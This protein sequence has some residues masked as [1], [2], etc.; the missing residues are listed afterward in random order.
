MK[1]RMPLHAHI[2]TRSPLAIAV[3]F[4]ASSPA[5]IL[6]A[7]AIGAVMAATMHVLTK[8]EPDM[9]DLDLGTRCGELLF[10][11]LYGSAVS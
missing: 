8:S 3:Y 11:L 4:G 7:M 2:C 6:T 5:T 10:L 1:G 9:P